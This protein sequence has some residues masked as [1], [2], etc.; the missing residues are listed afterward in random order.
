MAKI[1]YVLLCHTDPDGVVALARSLV[2]GGDYVAIHY[3]K[4]APDAGFAR[5]Q[6]ALGED[7]GVVFAKRVRC[8]W[9]EWSLVKASLRGLR[10]ARRAFRDATHFYLI[11]GDC[12][13]IKPGRHIRAALDGMDADLIETEDFFTSGWIRTGFVEERL[14]YRH[15]FN[16]RSQRGLYYASIDLQR[17]LGLRRRL[18]EGLD[19]RVGSQWWCLRRATVDKMLAMIAARPDIVR[20]FRQTWIP[21]ESFFQTLVHHLVPRHEIRSQSPTFLMFSDYGMPV[22]F[23]NDHYDFVLGQPEFFARKISKEA[24]ALKSALLSL[25]G[26]EAV[27]VPVSGEGRALY[28]FVTSRGRVGARYGPRFWERESDRAP[29]RSL[30]VVACKKWHVGRRFLGA[31]SQASN[32]PA[33]GY[34]FDE[35]DAGL[36]DLG[37]IQTSLAKRRRHRRAVVGLLFDHFEADRMA[38]CVDPSNIDLV[39]DLYSGKSDVRLLSLECD[40][41]DAYLEGHARRVGILG[42]A[43]SE[44]VR[45]RV[46][47]TIRNA[48]ED[49]IAAL[50]KARFPSFHRVSEQSD[51]DD[52]ARAIAAFL[53]LT[54]EAARQISDT[55]RLF[56]D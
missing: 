12:M 32:M 44:A 26:A 21:D 34:A 43:S 24:Q 47:P 29:A 13:P 41:S 3:D 4:R 6:E 33:I 31:I 48:I 9:G 19:I 36:P 14:V 54:D 2:K 39:R 16:E 52:N 23:Y 49:E 25:Y 46:L 53:S 15:L 51:P 56:A 35:D 50:R 45:R 37:G 30:F 11:S 40:Y 1:A 27:D 55:P 10:A 42:E 20:F 17:R 38:I 22:N 28:S 5:L 8:G 7:P 18:P